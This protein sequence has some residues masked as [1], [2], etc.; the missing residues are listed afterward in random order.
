MLIGTH[1]FLLPFCPPLAFFFFFF[2]SLFMAIPAA[3]GSSQAGVESE[4]HLLAYT[5][6]TAMQDP[7]HICILHHS[8]RQCHILN[9]LSEARDGT[10][11]LMI[12]SQIRFHCAI[13]GT[14]PFLFC[15]FSLPVSSSYRLCLSVNSA[16]DSSRLG[17][18]QPR[19][20]QC[21]KPRS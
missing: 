19:P 15:L 6:A 4:L 7:S 13:M 9:P 21:L 18:N 3:Y 17:A 11:N 16:A 8:S 20:G 2:F 14:P 12:P 10:R 5:T 1:I